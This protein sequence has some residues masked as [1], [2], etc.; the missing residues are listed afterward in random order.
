MDVP[1]LPSDFTLL[2]VLPALSAGGVEQTAVDIAAAVEDAGGRSIVASE[3]GRL[4]RGLAGFHVT[5]PLSSKSPLVIARN[6]FELSRLVREEKVSLV[7]A[8]SRAPAFSALWTAR[9]TRRPFVTTYAGVYHAG[10]ALKRWYNGVMAKGDVVI[11]NSDFTAT[12]L[13]AEHGVRPAKV[14]TIPRGIDLGYFDPKA[15]TERR[16]L[17]VRRSW[18][19]PDDDHRPVVLLAAR[20]SRWKGH[21]LMIDV[22]ALLARAGRRDF[23]LVL[24]GDD[25]GHAD[26][27]RSLDERIAVLG[28]Q[29]SVTLAGHISDMPAAYLASSLVVAPSLEPEAFGRTAV[30]P[31][32]MGRPVLAADHG[33][34][35]ETVAQGESGWLV[36]PG[37]VE[38]WAATLVEALDTDPERLAAMGEA[39]RERATALYSV[40]SMTAATLKVYMRLLNGVH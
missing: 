36:K 29:H 4:T 25:Q 22:A 33:G 3:G 13:M 16:V 32:A 23:R 15:V 7:H 39:G 30:E 10:N 26:Y 18:G 6:A 27:K 17:D 40:D 9:T 8:R 20:L 34:A 11:A 19:L 35:Q 38:A 12:R 24:A 1:N 37:D 31:Q 5:L 28:L 2:Q 14:V 21:G